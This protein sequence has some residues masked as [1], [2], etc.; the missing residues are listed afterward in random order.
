MSVRKIVSDKFSF[1]PAVRLLRLC[2]IILL[3]PVSVQAQT[4]SFWK[5]SVL[6]D[7]TEQDIASFKAAIA[8]AMVDA[9]DTNIVDWQSADKKFKGKILPKLT[10]ES[11]GKTC[12]RT[13]FQL[14]GEKEKPEHYR[15]D[16]CKD[17]DGNWQMASSSPDFSKTELESVNKFLS[18]V[19]EYQEPEQ[20]IS[21]NSDES[22]KNIVFVPLVKPD[23]PKDCRLAAITLLD[24]GAS[25]HGQ[26]RFC[27][28]TEGYW[29]YLPE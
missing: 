4:L 3:L 25:L 18:Q 6:A 5:T 15:F 9:K 23:L 24:D 28:N 10:Y 21:W 27:K 13:L 2:T 11:S 14:V 12:R 26:Y 17:N 20:P 19:L 8:D 16:F 7:F 22:N 29:N 1:L